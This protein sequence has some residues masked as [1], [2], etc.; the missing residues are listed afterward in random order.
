MGIERGRSFAEV[1]DAA[2]SAEEIQLGLVLEFCLAATA[3]MERKGLSRKC[4]AKRLGVSPSQVTRVL[5]GR[6]NLTLQTISEYAA[7]IG[8]SLHLSES[9][10]SPQRKGLSIVNP[11]ETAMVLPEETT[12]HS[13]EERVAL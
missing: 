13:R 6:A 1:G 7:A 3:E 8:I 5:S 4:L 11:R 10:P 2:L 12:P 9:L